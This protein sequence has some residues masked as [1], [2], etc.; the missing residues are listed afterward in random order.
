MR[1]AL[2]S[3]LC[4]GTVDS[5]PLHQRWRDTGDFEQACKDFTARQPIGRIATTE[6]IASI[7][8]WLASDDSRH[9][10]GQNFIPDGGI[11]A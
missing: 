8:V 1:R 7:V 5:P 6:E 4:P 11:T 10:T 9:A 3:S 2:R